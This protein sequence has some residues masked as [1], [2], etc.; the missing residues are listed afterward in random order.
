MTNSELGRGGG[1]PN[2][3]TSGS[4]APG[5]RLGQ[6]CD[7]DSE[8]HEFATDAFRAPQGILPGHL[9]DQSDGFGGYP[10]APNPVAGL[11]L[12]EQPEAL[13]IPA[14]E[15]IGLEDEERFLPTVG[16]AGEEDDP[17]AI[18]L[19]EAWFLDQV[20]EE[21]QLLAEESILGDELGLG[22][23]DI[24]RYGEN[25]GNAGGLGQVAESLFQCGHC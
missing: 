6:A 4:S 20:L 17:E 19:G 21:D 16:P 3:C 5:L 9:L 11:E 1:A 13:A 18:G 25:D 8:F 10:G 23:G 22:A 14:Q 12:R 15:G 7:L 2:A 24:A